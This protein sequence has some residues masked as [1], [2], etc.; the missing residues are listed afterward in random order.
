MRHSQ[1]AAVWAERAAVAGVE[2]QLGRIGDL[3]PIAGVVDR[4]V[5][6]GAMRH[7][8][9]AAVWTERAVVRGVGWQL[10]RILS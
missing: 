6:R 1:Q 5:G 3:T 8:Q 2:W 10:G 7:S 9:Q 4:D